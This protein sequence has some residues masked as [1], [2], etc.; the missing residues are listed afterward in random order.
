M[1]QSLSDTATTGEEI[2]TASCPH[3]PSAGGYCPSNKQPVCRLLRLSPVWCVTPPRATT[4]CRLRCF[5][6]IHRVWLP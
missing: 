5:M 2:S 1:S 6:L 3:C 4:N